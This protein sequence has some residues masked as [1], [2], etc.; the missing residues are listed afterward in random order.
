M[1]GTIAI[2][3]SILDILR[4]SEC[5]RNKKASVSMTKE[6]LRIIEKR[7]FCI[8]RVLPLEVAQLWRRSMRPSKAKKR[9]TI[10][11]SPLLERSRSPTNEAF[12]L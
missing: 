12:V 2:G 1:M 8:G 5:P 11:P 3:D 6:G 4:Q 10:I 9:A 7:V